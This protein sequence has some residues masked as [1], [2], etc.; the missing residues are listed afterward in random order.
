MKSSIL[1]VDDEPITRK[2]LTD[3]LR[4]EGYTVASAPNGQAAV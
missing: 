2:S 3:I 1:I 4:L